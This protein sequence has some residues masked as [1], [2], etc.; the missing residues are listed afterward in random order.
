MN[1]T[2]KEAADRLRL[3]SGTL[4]NM[5]CKGGG[6]KYIQWG[7]KVLY[8]LAEIEAFEQKHLRSN[9]AQPAAKGNQ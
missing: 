7:R 4:A 9:T 1:L 2:P 5:R 3:S 6:P 8:P